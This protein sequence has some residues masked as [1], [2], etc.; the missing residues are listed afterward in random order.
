[1][2]DDKRWRK[3]LKRAR[4]EK[5]LTLDQL[6]RL[7]GTTKGQISMLENG[8]RPFT[9]KLLAAIVNELGIDFADLFCGCG[10]YK[11]NSDPA[12]FNPKSVR[13]SPRI[14]PLRAVH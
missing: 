11:R 6:A 14:I 10:F 1:M 5:G 8:K 2:A 12:N 4:Q 3:N 9:Q 7:A 13:Q